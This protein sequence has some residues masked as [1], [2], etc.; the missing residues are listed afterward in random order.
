[1]T[2]QQAV[3]GLDFSSFV[4]YALTRITELDPTLDLAAA[5][6]VLNLHR[7]ASTIVYDLESS[8]HRPRG[9]SWAGFRLLFALWVSGPLESSDAARIAGMSRQ[10][11]SSL[12]NTLE[13]Q[14]LLWRK[15]VQHDGR[16]VSFGL[17]DKGREL[18]AEA[19]H[20]HNIREQMWAEMLNPEERA[21]LTSALGKLLAAAPHLD[22]RRRD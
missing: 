5:A 12:A 1:M 2:A 17:T 14:A 22:V 18:I 9:L 6:L 10:A 7:A 21:A 19:Y 13:R 15:R 3:G 8:A 16:V 11:T 4:R 20:E